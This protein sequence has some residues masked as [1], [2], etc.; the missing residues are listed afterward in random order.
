[1]LLV[2]DAQDST[3]GKNQHGG[4][5]KETGHPI[6]ERE[7]LH[8]LFCTYCGGPNKPDD[9]FCIKCGK[10][11]T[12]MSEKEISKPIS[13][14]AISK[15]MIEKE[16]LDT[17]GS[18]Q[19]TVSERE[20]F[21]DKGLTQN[22]VTE[23]RTLRARG[24]TQRMTLQAKKTMPTGTKILISIGGVV[25]ILLFIIVG[26]ST[27]KGKALFSKGA[28][29]KLSGKQ[30]SS[31][32]ADNSVESGMS[33]RMNQITT[34]VVEIAKPSEDG[35][36]IRTEHGKLFL[37]IE[38]PRGKEI[39]ELLQESHERKSPV[40]I[41]YE[42]GGLIANVKP[43]ET[44]DEI[45]SVIYKNLNAAENKDIQSYMATIHEQSEVYAPTKQA[46]QQMF[47]TYDLKCELKDVKVIEK[48]DQEAKVEYVQI[49]KKL[50]GPAFR[51]NKLT[52]IHILK[53]SDGKWKIYN[54][55]TKNIEYLD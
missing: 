50:N 8:P 27:E 45:T 26:L 20:T 55:E 52:G 3:P 32:A 47:D 19:N 38:N 17:R 46:M 36:L 18:A 49:T 24:P 33:T 31:T 28:N 40:I 30:V 10:P 51:N 54:S 6:S 7:T 21:R 34:V 16:T 4:N 44:D 43:T 29:A 11:L 22:T 12:Q 1:M 15:P 41:T 14:K 13:E 42:E 9:S 23:K 35:V 53:K 39:F 37:H 2:F 25:I 48:S 5:P